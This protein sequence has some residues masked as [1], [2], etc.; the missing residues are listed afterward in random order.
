MFCG[1]D[2][3]RVGVKLAHV[4]FILRP[5]GRHEFSDNKLDV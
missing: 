1:C 5:L 2:P 3:F 4:V